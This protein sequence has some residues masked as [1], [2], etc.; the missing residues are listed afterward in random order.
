MFAGIKKTAMNLRIEELCKQRGM[1]MSDLA[2]KTGVNSANLAYSLK[3]NPTLSRL[4]AVA[5][6]LGVGIAE[7]FAKP[8]SYSNEVQGYLEY[9]DGIHIV[10]GIDDIIAAE[11]SIPGL[12]SVPVY[13]D[14]K[15]LRKQV[16]DFIHNCIKK[17]TDVAFI[18]G[19]IDHREL[20]HLCWDGDSERFLLTLMSKN[21]VFSFDILEYGD[22]DDGYDIDGPMGLVQML[23]NDLEASLECVDCIDND[24]VY[25]DK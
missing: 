3:G 14:I 1:R 2:A 11:T 15:T 21:T 8:R 17:E 16:K 23:I 5:G 6:V 24:N 9:Q 20:F 22:P 12:L 7:L 10:S 19:R 18:A 25:I 4:E 13:T